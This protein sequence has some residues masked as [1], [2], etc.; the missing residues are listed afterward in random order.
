MKV[1]VW[2]SSMYII[3]Y[4]CVC[5]CTFIFSIFKVMYVLGWGKNMY[6]GVP[7]LSRHVPIVFRALTSHHAVVAGH[8]KLEDLCQL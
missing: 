5:R 6:G 7:L 4:I 3:I 1:Y 2:Y 8:A